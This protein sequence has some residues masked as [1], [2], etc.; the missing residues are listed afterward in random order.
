MATGGTD[1]LRLNELIGSQAQGNRTNE[2]MEIFHS[3][4]SRGGGKQAPPVSS[5]TT[6]K[7][8]TQVD[9]AQ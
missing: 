1:Q 9:L 4:E 5:P 8:V 3:R 2:A 7:L 6:L